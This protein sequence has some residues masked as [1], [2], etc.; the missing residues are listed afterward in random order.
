MRPSAKLRAAA[1]PDCWARR[2]ATVLV[3]SLVVLPIAPV[4]LLKLGMRDFEKVTGL[5]NCRKIARIASAPP[6]QE[7]VSAESLLDL[8]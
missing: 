7:I 1:T 5:S 2:G 8:R 4:E 6:I 3:A